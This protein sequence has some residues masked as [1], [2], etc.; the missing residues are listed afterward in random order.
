M[1]TDSGTELDFE[2][3]ATNR[4]LLLIENGTQ[5]EMLTNVEAFLVKME[6]MRSPSAIRSGGGCDLLRRATI[7][8]TIKTG[9]QSADI[10]EDVDGQIVT[11]SASVMPRRNTW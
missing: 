10:N 7:Q 4:K 9:G 2:F 11:M 5:R 3:D 6:P 1:F 8:L